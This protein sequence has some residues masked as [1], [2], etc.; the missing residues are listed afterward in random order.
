MWPCYD[1]LVAQNSLRL[2]KRVSV[3]TCILPS[4]KGPNMDILLW[5]HLLLVPSVGAHEQV[6]LFISIRHAHWLVSCI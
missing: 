2:G 6:F 5:A 3:K 1:V 4:N